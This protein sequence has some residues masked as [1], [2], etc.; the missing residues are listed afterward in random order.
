MKKRKYNKII[1]GEYYNSI[2]D[3]LLPCDIILTEYSRKSVVPNSIAYMTGS[4][5]SHVMLYVG[6][7]KIVEYTLGG[8]KITDLKHYIKDKYRITIRRLKVATKDQLNKIEA[9]A[10]EDA[11]KNMPYD[12]KSY[13]GHIINC[14]LIKFGFKKSRRIDNIFDNEGYVCSS[15]VD[16][17]LRSGDIVLYP[18]FAKENIY[19]ADIESSKKLV[20]VYKQR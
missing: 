10:L 16:R 13:A 20:T 7:G 5:N 3:R 1:A 14:I 12:Y 18:D 17:W 8:C 4:R 9:L 19:P 2:L 15:G 11:R 6:N